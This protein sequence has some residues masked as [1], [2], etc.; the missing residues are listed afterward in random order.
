[1]SWRDRL[2]ETPL[3]FRGVRIVWDEETHA[4]GFT[5]DKRVYP[6]PAGWDIEQM[7]QVPESF[8]IKGKLLGADYLDKKRALLAALR[9]EGAGELILPGVGSLN[10]L[11]AKWNIKERVKAKGMAE[12]TISFDRARPSERQ[13]A[14]LSSDPEKLRNELRTATAAYAKDNL[15]VSSA[16]L[17]LEARRAFGKVFQSITDTTALLQG[18]AGPAASVLWTI[19]QAES[20]LDTLLRMPT[21]LTASLFNCITALTSFIATGKKY[22]LL[23]PAR[24]GLK[25]L[26][27][28]ATYHI[29]PG[30]DEFHNPIPRTRNTAT[31][32]HIHKVVSLY[33]AVQ[34]VDDFVPL[35]ASDAAEQ[36]RSLVALSTAAAGESAAENEAITGMR[37]YGAGVLRVAVAAGKLAG[38]KT[39]AISKPRNLLAL[40]TDLGAAPAVLSALNRPAD[41][42]A[43]RGVVRYV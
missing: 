40:S 19:Q 9:M 21:S 12:V 38:E 5:N 1:M 18:K 41:A 36:S 15:D 27:S 34:L 35:S 7:S 11:V 10:V 42:F 32:E 39:A 20:Q 29:D 30:R 31:A 8:S 28:A 6:S 26:Y 24:S 33:G 22:A 14:P 25:S 23:H 43:V 2:R 3:S 17:L 37:V 16:D 4:G 13:A